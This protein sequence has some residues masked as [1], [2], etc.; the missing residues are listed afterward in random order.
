MALRTGI[1]PV[2]PDRKSGVLSHYTNG[3]KQSE[4]QDSNLRPPASKAGKQPDRYLLRY[5]ST[6]GIRTR[7]HSRDSRA[8]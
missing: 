4:K 3:A 5:C 7:N 6:D 8:L 2:F 1:E